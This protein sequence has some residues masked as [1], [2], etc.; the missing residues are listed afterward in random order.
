MEQGEIDEATVWASARGGDPA[1]FG[2]VF[3]R[4]RDRVFG[5]ALRLMRS[6]RDAE[7][8]TA[9][10]FLEAWR[11]R[12]AVRVVDGSII[13]WLLVTTNFVVRN[14][15][16]TMRR[17]RDAMAQL[18]P[19]TAAG[20]SA[21]DHAD[22]VG[23]RLDRSARDRRVRDAF[24]Q[25]SR[26]D[27]DVITLCVLEEFTTGQTAAALGIPVGTVKSRLSRAKRRLAA[28]TGDIAIDTPTLHDDPT[29]STGG[30]R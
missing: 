29:T 20:T 21:D 2:V 8:V 16:R 18:P 13:G 10:V 6:P 7:D 26:A 1:A 11:K 4:H 27:Q 25:L 12:D 24:A 22:A 14:L 23:E 17:Y 28:L 3:D 30:A 19:A 15:V 9:L 5:Q